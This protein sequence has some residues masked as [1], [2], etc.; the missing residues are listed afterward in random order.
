M[1]DCHLA[2]MRRFDIGY[3]LLTWESDI[4]ALG[5]GAGRL[6]CCGRRGRSSM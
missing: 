5:S 2:T 6:S 3:D 4:I 1:V